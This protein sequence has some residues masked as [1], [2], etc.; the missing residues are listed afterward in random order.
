MVGDVIVMMTREPAPAVTPRHLST[1]A[2]LV[3]HRV[4]EEEEVG[5]TSGR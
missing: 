1:G 5:S 3:N 2:Q 4:E